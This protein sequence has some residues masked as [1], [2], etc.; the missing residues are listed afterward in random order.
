MLLVYTIY[1]YISMYT[2]I[3]KTYISDI[4]TKNQVIKPEQCLSRLKESRGRCI[5]D[6]AKPQFMGK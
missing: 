5:N 6:K 2:Y 3:H 1:T 4:L